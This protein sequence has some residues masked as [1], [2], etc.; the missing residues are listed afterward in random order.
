MTVWQT[1]KNWLRGGCVYFTALALF[2]IL[3]NF[4]TGN[5]HDVGRINTLLFLLMFPCGLCLSFAEILLRSQK[6]SRWARILLHYLITLLS[7]YLLLVL[8]SNA[9]FSGSSLLVLFVLLTALYWIIFGLVALTLRR[10]R[11]LLSEDD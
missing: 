1:V 9:K 6:L 8:P 7:F 4:I 5:V 10:V 11:R 3:L 2:F